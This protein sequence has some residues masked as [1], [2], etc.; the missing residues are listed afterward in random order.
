MSRTL[1]ELSKKQ[2][3]YRFHFAVGAMA[4]TV[5]N[6]GMIVRNSR[7]LITSID[8]QNLIDRLVNFLVAAFK[9]PRSGGEIERDS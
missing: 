6:S 5:T 8:P 1:P 7:G 3:I 4:M 9:A 2:L